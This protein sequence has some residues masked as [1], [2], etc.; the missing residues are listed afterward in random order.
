MNFDLLWR[1]GLFN[2]CSVPLIVVR[3]K[4]GAEIPIGDLGDDGRPVIC[5]VSVKI[6]DFVHQTSETFLAGNTLN[7]SEYESFL[8]NCVQD[9]SI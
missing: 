8:E 6:V 5:F 4:R 2:D 9:T 7:P 3:V 1:V